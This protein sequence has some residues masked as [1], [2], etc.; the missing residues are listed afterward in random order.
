MKN[1]PEKFYREQRQLAEKEQKRLTRLVRLLALYRF[2]AFAAIF[3]LFWLLHRH[4]FWA[5]A[6]AVTSLAILL[7][8]VKWNVGLEKQLKRNL[9][10]L[11]LIDDELKALQFEYLHF[12][13][14]REFLDINHPF[15]YDLDLF[16]EGS[17]FQ[18]LNRTA[19]YSGGRLLAGWLLNPPLSGREIRQRQEAVR[20]LSAMPGWMLNFRT[21]GNLLRESADE[22]RSL[23]A[24]TETPLKLKQ[25]GWLRIA[26]W[27]LPLL[28]LLSA[29]PLLLGGSHLLL[30]F[31]V[32]VQWGFLFSFK[33]EIAG[34]YRIFGEKSKLIEKYL[35]LLKI[36]EESA[37]T[38]EMTGA[39]RQKITRPEPAGVAVGKLLKWLARFE[40]RQ[41]ILVGLVLNSL[42]LWDLRC[43]FQLW[44]WHAQNR[45]KLAGWL[46]SVET[47]DALVS[48]ANFSGNYPAF[49]FPEPGDDD[50]ILE[51]VGMG[52][53]LIRP[54]KRINNDFSVQGWSKVLIVT[55]ANMAGKSTFLRTVGVNL[56]LARLGAP[57]C[58]SAMKFTPVTLFTNMRTTDSLLKEESYFFA[59][60]KRLSGLLERL[61]SGEKL[62]VILDEMLKGT[63]SEDK[64]NGS[65][66]L[67]RQLVQTASVTIIATHDLKL[68]D[69]EQQFPENVRNYCF[70]ISLSG[71]QMVFD[72]QLKPGVTRTMNATWLMRKMGIIPSQ[73]TP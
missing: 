19:T 37:F 70:E 67:V 69:M 66:E 54:E 72:Y 47:M 12:P 55:G 44:K 33:K 20:E 53:P 32:L 1:S 64:L 16:G 46:E 43:V 65:R 42:F 68:A 26:G 2:A 40:Y 29:I 17:L 3:V 59:E 62:M 49:S 18:F 31:F 14:G 15:S 21:E 5:T 7:L 22:H 56:L 30:L 8:L 50:F 28:T 52:H 38:S 25:A 34:F 11:Q 4:L 58:A 13:D 9:V 51:A 63:N 24:W 39:L 27:L 48:L 73:T 60:L 10:L 57:V 61:R 45:E 71:Q 41:N 36:I 35:S 6:A 23:L